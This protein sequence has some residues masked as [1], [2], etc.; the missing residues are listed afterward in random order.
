MTT[1]ILNRRPWVNVMMCKNKRRKIGDRNWRFRHW[2]WVF[3]LWDNFAPRGQLRPW[4]PKFMPGG[5]IK[6]GLWLLD[7]IYYV[8][9][10]YIQCYFY[11][12]CWRRSALEVFGGIYQW[13]T[14]LRLVDWCTNKLCHFKLPYLLRSQNKHL[15]GECLVSLDVSL[16]AAICFVFCKIILRFFCFVWR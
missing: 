1:L 8:A 11:L 12:T 10:K 14:G 15:N 5:V 7:G 16:F 3:C 13:Q 9:T 6:T 2:G 4:G